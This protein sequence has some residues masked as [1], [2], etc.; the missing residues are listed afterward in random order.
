MANPNGRP[1]KHIDWSKLDGMLYFDAAMIVCADEL[2]ISHDCLE[3]RVKKEK[4]MSFAEYKKLK[5]GK[6]A[7]RLKQKM[8]N[9]GL[10]GDN[11]CMIFALKNISEWSDRTEVVNSDAANKTV[12]L[13]YKLEREKDTEDKDDSDNEESDS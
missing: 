1:K 5:L 3:R 12:V 4:G 13:K 7:L 8:I 6:T 11:T 9:K 2:G 10:A